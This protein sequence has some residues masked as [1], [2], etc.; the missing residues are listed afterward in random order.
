MG[1][2]WAIFATAVEITRLLNFAGDLRP[3][4][5]VAVG[6]RVVTIEENEAIVDLGVGQR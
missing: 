1:D 4:L 3:L 2:P 5:V 6:Y